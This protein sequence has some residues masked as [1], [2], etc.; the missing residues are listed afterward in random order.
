MSS[1]QNSDDHMESSNRYDDIVGVLAVGAFLIGTATG[2]A[3]ALLGISVAALLLL[4]V[5]YRKRLFRGSL[6]VALVAAIIA[7]A[8]GA[9][10]AIY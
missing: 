2:N 10:L 5:Y 7:A 1:R 9:A 6:L 8:I 3:F 4:T